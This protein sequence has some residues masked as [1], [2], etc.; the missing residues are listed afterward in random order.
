MNLMV[1]TILII[2][3]VFMIFTNLTIFFKFCEFHESN[4]FHDLPE[5]NGARWTGSIVVEAHV[6][7]RELGR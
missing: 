7:E 4:D 3:T 5:G 2:C 1:S 6:F